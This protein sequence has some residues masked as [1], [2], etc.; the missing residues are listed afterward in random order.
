[1]RGTAQRDT[2]QRK[3]I[4]EVLTNAERPLA[5]DEVLSES[6][7]AVPSLGLATVYRYLKVLAS[8]GWLA[9]VDLPGGTRYELAERPHHH[10]FLCRV[11]NQVFDVP[12]CPGSVEQHAP[13]GFEVESHEITLHGRCAGCT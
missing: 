5:P 8:D 12:G 13:P 7:Q 9:E 4:R 2:R 3:A 6:Q 11:C 10:Y 1:M